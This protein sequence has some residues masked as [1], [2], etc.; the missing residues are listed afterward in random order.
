MP[1]SLR[2]LLHD[3]EILTTDLRD[4]GLF[5]AAG[6]MDSVK[7]AIRNREAYDQAGEDEE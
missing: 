4:A 2:D 7:E 3:C 6:Y 5:T 1:K